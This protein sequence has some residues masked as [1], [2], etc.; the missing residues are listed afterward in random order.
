MSKE[1]DYKEFLAENDENETMF[2]N[3]IEKYP[4]T[5]WGLQWLG[6]ITLMYIFY[7]I[8]QWLIK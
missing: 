7:L 4:N 2:N 1:Q 5:A 6:V 8:L 3:F